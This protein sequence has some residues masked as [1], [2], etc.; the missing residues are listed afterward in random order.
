M[1]GLKNYK[2]DRDITNND[3]HRS[4]DSALLKQE[5]EN[6][7]NLN[8]GDCKW[9]IRHGLSRSILFTRNSD[10]IKSEISNKIIEFYGDRVTKVH[11][12]YMYYEGNKIT[13]TGKIDTIYGT[14][15]VG[16]AR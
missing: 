13:F 7:L 5:L 6:F 1:F 14:F 10:A 3:Y 15:E 4:E 9:D 11:S 16:G 2:G 12:M 8:E